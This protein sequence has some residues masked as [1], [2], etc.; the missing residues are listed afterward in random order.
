MFQK[1]IVRLPNWI[2]DFVMAT[3]VLSDLR[4]HFPAARITA[5]CPSPICELLKEDPAVDELFCFTEPLCGGA[6]RQNLLNIT[7]TLRKGNY[8]LGILLTNSF[9]SAWWFW[10]GRVK[11]RLGYAVDWRSL[12][13]TDCM[14]PPETKIHQ[15]DSYKHLVQ[16]LGIPISE[17]APRLFLS[18]KDEERA[19]QILYQRGYRS[20]DALIGINARAAYG[21]AKCW[22]PER[23]HALAKKFLQEKDLFVLFFGD[24]A[25][26]TLVQK[27]CH[28]LP[29]RAINLTGAT[30]LS[31]LACLIKHCDVLVTNDSGPMHIGAALHTPIVALFGSTDDLITG[32]W[33]QKEAIV[34][35][36]LNCS[37]CFKRKC[38]LDFR[39]MNRIEVAEVAQKALERRKKRV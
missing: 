16:P 20:G 2:G 19:R 28:D 7:Q 17:T 6:K 31:E 39:C 14:E 18:E 38:P 22:P 10:L 25:S 27:I 33:G 32:P 12:L 4:H 30:N 26:R 8:D 9:S 24:A 35:K 13:M 23:F 36:H 34:N 3:P 11:R 29:E 37:P 15:V 1:I 5:M 21:E